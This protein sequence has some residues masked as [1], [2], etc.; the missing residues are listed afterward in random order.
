MIRLYM[1][2]TGAAVPLNRGLP[3]IVLRINSDLYV[4]D[5]GEGCQQR[6]FNTGLS[7]VKIRS[8]FITHLHGDH[9]LGLPGMLQSM[10][11]L[12]RRNDLTIVGPRNLF[13]LLENFLKLSYGQPAFKIS[14]V[15]AKDNEI[16]YEDSNIVVE[17]FTVKHIGDSFGYKINIKKK[18]K[19]IIYT[20]DTKPIDKIAE[21]SKNA[22]ILIHE[23][24][25]TSI[26]REEAYK[27]GHSTAADAALIASKS[28][29]KTLILTHI[30]SRYN[31]VEPLFYDAYRFFRNT[32]VAEDYMTIIV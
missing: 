12:D 28:N 6:M 14:Y 21:I 4:F 18:R 11:L 30:S 8:I 7:V 15:D 27:Q 5:T 2:G 3:C 32:I 31:S 17:S 1:L 29:V 20:G 22:D 23:A 24:T 25:F 9:F 16:V 13:N 10:H 26:L 19:S